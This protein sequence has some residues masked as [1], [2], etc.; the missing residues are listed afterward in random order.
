[1]E[2]SV[3]FNST[4]RVKKEPIDV[5]LGEND[6]IVI[7]KTADVNNFQFLRHPQENLIRVLQK[8]DDNFERELDDLAIELECKDMKPSLDLLAVTKI[9]NWSEDH[10]AVIENNKEYQ[11]Q[12]IVK[13]QAL[14]TVK[15]ESLVDDANQLSMNSNCELSEPKK[16]ETVVKN[17]DYKHNLKKHV[18]DMSNDKIA[19]PCDTCGKTFRFKSNLKIHIDSMHLKI[20]HGCDICGKTFSKKGNLQTH[21]DSVHN[22]TK[23]YECDVCGKKFSRKDHLKIHIDSVHKGTRYP[24]D[25]CR[26]TFCQKWNLK[27]HIGSVHNSQKPF[28]CD[29]CGKKFPLKGR[30]KIHIDS[31]HNGITYPCD[32]CEKTFTQKCTLKPHIDSIHKGIIYPCDICGKTYSRKSQ[33][34][35]HVKSVHN[36][37][38][39]A[40]ETCGKI[41]E[42]KRNLQ[43]HI[44]MAQHSRISI[45]T[46]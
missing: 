40:C 9:E 41:F 5:L 46:Q 18:V 2:S 21:I 19:Y 33:L 13:I 14:D 29:T 10:L 7:D 11:T 34:N 24:C 22:R 17:G 31:A 32:F 26:K 37:T 6:Y 23:S 43:K 36:N 42:Q 38:T 16:R 27:I 44:D 8:Y 1:M 30:L 12:K 28:K 3:V 45:T 39:Y 20:T 15:K 25:F 35:S 4:V